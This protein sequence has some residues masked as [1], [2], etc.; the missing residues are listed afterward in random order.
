[1]NNVNL[2]KNLKTVENMMILKSMQ[3]KNPNVLNIDNEDLI[4][5]VQKYKKINHY[6]INFFEQLEK[7]N[8]P[9]VDNT[10][11]TWETKYKNSNEKE[12]YITFQVLESNKKITFVTEYLS[13][14]EMSYIQKIMCK[15]EKTL[16]EE[17]NE[18]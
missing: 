9:I 3:I 14:K 10:I 1:M 16:K 15:E 17:N 5:K 4:N 2:K 7:H 11:I 18:Q 12:T 13:D 6:I 8:F